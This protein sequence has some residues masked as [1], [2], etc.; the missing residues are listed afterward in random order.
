VRT[1]KGLVLEGRYRLDSLIAT[2]GMGE[3]WKGWDQDLDRETAVKVLREEYAFDEGFLKRFRA[4]ARHTASLSHD[5]IAALYDYGEIDGR[6]YIVMELCKGRPLSE[7]IEEHPDGL[8]EDRV[9]SVLID[10]ARALD[11]AHAKGVVHRDVKPENIL[12]DDADDWHMKITDFGIARSQDQARLTKTGLVMGTAQYLSPEQAMGKQATSLSDLYALG[13][14]AYEMLVGHRPFTGASQVEIAMAQVKK[15]PPALPDSVSPDLRRLVMMLLAK[16]PANRPRS[17]AAVAR[18]L[19]SIQRGEEPRFT[20]GAIPAGAAGAG[21]SA[22]SGGSASS[23]ATGENRAGSGKPS[24]SPVGTR[25]AAMPLPRTHRRRGIRHRSG[26]SGPSALSGA[27]APSASESGASGSR[28]AMPASGSSRTPSASRLSGPGSPLGPGSVG[29]PAG[30]PGSS[31]DRDAGSG[32]AAGSATGAGSASADGA[33]TGISTASSGRTSRST[34]TG[35]RIG[36]FTVPGFVLLLIVI[37]VAA[38]AIG[39]GVGIIPSGF[40]SGEAAH[41]AHARTMF[42][43]PPT[44]DFTRTVGQ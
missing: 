17:A 26:T 22:A 44:G 4:E 36:P 20:T 3:V 28:A 6:A 7:I 21:S 33:G 37:V 42:A 16:A 24:A 10:L 30:A 13:I 15:Q 5:T 41:A 12:V 29:S 11:A 32:T 14:V 35:S 2:G 9:V 8:P 23:G 1:A 39:M 25:T 43:S 18:I 19:E 31:S 27:S 40:L 34:S 38:V